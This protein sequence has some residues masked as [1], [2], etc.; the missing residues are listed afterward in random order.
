METKKMSGEVQIDPLFSNVQR[1][2]WT[3]DAPYPG[4]LWLANFFNSSLWEEL[5]TNIA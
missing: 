2:V 3:G 1:F 4:R 5:K